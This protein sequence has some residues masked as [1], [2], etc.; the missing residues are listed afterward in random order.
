M[1]FHTGGVTER[2]G[3]LGF[4]FPDALI[5][6]D[7]SQVSNRNEVRKNHGLQT[8][9]GLGKKL[10]LLI[11]MISSSNNEIEFKSLKPWVIHIR[12]HYSDCLIPKDSLIKIQYSIE[13]LLKSNN[14]L[15]SRDYLGIHVRLGDLL[16]LKDKGPTNPALVQRILDEM[17]SKFPM[18]NIV[19]FSDSPHL[20]RE[21]LDFSESN[22]IT[23][24]DQGPWETLI[25][26]SNSKIIIGTSS[27]ISIWA[28]LLGITK[29][30]LLTA[31][32]PL[33]LQPKVKKNLG[34]SD[35]PLVQFY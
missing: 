16:T 20:V 4:F 11:G 3:E 17:S 8:L 32:L 24:L 5:V 31:A 15:P 34:A 25:S 14:N 12:G 29:G 30:S 19:A 10:M 13:R 22:E 33:N 9:R 35:N 6:H 23:I 21:V 1:V 7:F 26:L 27:K 28:V 18:L 2:V